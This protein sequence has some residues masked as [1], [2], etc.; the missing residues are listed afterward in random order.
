MNGEMM[1]LKI[2]FSGGNE[3]FYVEKFLWIMICRMGVGEEGGEMKLWK[4][5]SQ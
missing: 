2:C 3:I 5:L 4:S 1:I